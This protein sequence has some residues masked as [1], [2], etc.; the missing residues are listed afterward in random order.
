MVWSRRAPQPCSP[1]LRTFRA[2]RCAWTVRVSGFKLPAIPSSST[3]ENSA[4]RAI[5]NRGS[6]SVRTAVG[7]ISSPSYLRFATHREWPERR[8]DQSAMDRITQPA[9]HDLRMRELD[10]QRRL[11]HVTSRETLKSCNG[12]VRISRPRCS[13][14]FAIRRPMPPR[15]CRGRGGAGPPALTSTRV[16]VDGSR[17]ES[18]DNAS[19][20]AAGIALDRASRRGPPFLRPRRSNVGAAA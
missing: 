17:Q 2:A 5:S 3:S 6:L 19:P 9:L 13:R 1:S 14:S 20:I 15:R 7:L 8:S 18:R 4:R 12:E 10:R 16:N 11:S